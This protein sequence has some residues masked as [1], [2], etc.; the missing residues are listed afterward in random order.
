MVPTYSV[1]GMTRDQWYLIDNFMNSIAYRKAGP[2]GGIDKGACLLF[3]V[4]TFFKKFIRLAN[5]LPVF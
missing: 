3:G 1:K 4:K 5:V 2:W